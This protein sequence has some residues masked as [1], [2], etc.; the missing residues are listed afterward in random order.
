MTST[1]GDCRV[2]AKHQGQGCLIGGPLIWQDGDVVVYHK[3]PGPTGRVFLGHLF[4]ETRRHASGWLP[5]LCFERRH[6][7]GT[8]A[9]DRSADDGVIRGP[10]LPSSPPT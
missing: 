4:V 5:P 1:A 2:C 10:G 8:A 3:P 6:H 9:R 7:A